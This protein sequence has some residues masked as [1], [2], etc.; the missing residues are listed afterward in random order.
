MASANRPEYLSL[1][2]IEASSPDS[3]PLSGMLRT[4]TRGLHEDAESTPFMTRVLDGTTTPAEYG[5]LVAALLPIYEALEEGLR[6][7][8]SHAVVGPFWEPSL[9]RGP[10]LA[11]DLADLVDAGVRVDRA[12]GR[13]AG[14]PLAAR[15][16]DVARDEPV[17]LAAHAYVR[18]MGD[19]AGG[20]MMG[21]ALSSVLGP[22]GS[23]GTAFFRF[24]SDLNP[25]A[26]VRRIRAA[27]DAIPAPTHTSVISEAREAFRFHIRLARELENSVTPGV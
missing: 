12:L 5:S 8:E 6:A 19:L 1:V 15:I 11:K 24:P 27:L 20:R 9:A 14:T 22:P 16:R 7:H 13:A 18:Y 4:S 17:R 25:G 26:E 2:M 3:R 21:R 23:P 10:A